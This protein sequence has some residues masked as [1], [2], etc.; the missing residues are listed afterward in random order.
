MREDETRQF[1]LGISK[2]ETREE[3]PLMAVVTHGV[4]LISMIVLI[5][6]GFFIHSPF[7][8]G[9]MIINK[10]FH[11]MFAFIL[12]ATGVVRM[13]WAFFGKGSAPSGGRAK[14]RDYKFFLPQ[15][16]NR[17]KLLPM[18]KYYLFLRGTHPRTQKYNPLQKT[19]YVSLILFITVQIITG[20]SLLTATAQFF[21]PLTYLLGGT[22]TVRSIHY[23]TMWGFIFI[24]MIHV[25]L[26]LTETIHELPLMFLWRE[27]R[28]AEERHGLERDESGE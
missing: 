17:G 11:T 7:Y 12:I 14:I 8:Q 10:T 24:T 2:H 18:I 20:F 22:A 3:H 15:K 23:L 27:A 9:S 19:A 1:K 13:D 28:V 5:W 4:H 16:E 21:L 6:T 25:Y 26:V